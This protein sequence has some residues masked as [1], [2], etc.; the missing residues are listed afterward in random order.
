MGTRYRLQRE[1]DS[2]LKY[3][4]R[5]LELYRGI[6]DERGEGEV[7]G[8]IGA[9]YFNPEDFEKALD[10]Y[11]EALRKRTGVDDRQLTGST[12]NGIGSVY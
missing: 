10:Y 12:Y 1:P 6:G 3:Y 5:A 9:V 7:L 11:Q 4:N 2:A 8:G